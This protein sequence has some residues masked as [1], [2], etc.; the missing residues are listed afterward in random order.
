MRLKETDVQ[1]I[2]GFRTGSFRS[3]GQIMEEVKAHRLESDTASIRQAN[4]SL[5]LT[6]E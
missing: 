4:D 1:H 2:A 3:W 5:M 6:F